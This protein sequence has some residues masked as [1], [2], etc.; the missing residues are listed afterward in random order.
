MKHCFAFS[1]TFAVFAIF[2]GVAMA[3]DCTAE[4]RVSMLKRY[5]FLRAG[6]VLTFGSYSISSRYPYEKFF[7][8][9]GLNFPVN[10]LT[11]ISPECSGLE[12]H[13]GD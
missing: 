6:Q 13:V 12:M 4:V 11:K 1:L 10:H 7:W 3:G 5:P 9:R 8:T 2:S